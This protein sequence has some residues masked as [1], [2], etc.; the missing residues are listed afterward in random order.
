MIVDHQIDGIAD[1]GK[2]NGCT[3]GIFRLFDLI[4]QKRKDC[5]HPLILELFF[6][7][8]WI[9]PVGF[10]DKLSCQ[11]CSMISGLVKSHDIP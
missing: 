5:H 2:V 10:L 3:E 9:A 8:E 4:L 6:M 1:D 11:T 7:K